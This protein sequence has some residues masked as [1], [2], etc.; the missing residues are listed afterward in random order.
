MP[1]QPRKSPRTSQTALEVAARDAQ[2][3]EMRKL[4]ASLVAIAAA[5]GYANQ[6]GAWKAVQ[7]ELAR[8][9]EHTLE[10]AEEYRLLEGE[11][12]NDLH[13]RTVEIFSRHHPVL[14]KGQPVLDANGQPLDDDGIKL[15]AAA[16]LLRQQ[17]SYRKLFGIDAP[18]KVEHTGPDGEPIPVE[19]RVAELAERLRAIPAEAS[20]RIAIEQTNGGST[21]GS[22]GEA[23][24]D[25]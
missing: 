20:E 7:R 25:G 22:S 3:F 15:R 12:L 14:Y 13:R 18:A 8:L 5:L 19:L 24:L 9:R 6:S 2:A 1:R 17:E 10:S 16:E 4:G 21:N 11:R 23:H